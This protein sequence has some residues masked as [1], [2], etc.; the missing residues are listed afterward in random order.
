MRTVIL[1]VTNQQSLEVINEVLLNGDENEDCDIEGD[2]SAVTG[3]N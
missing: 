3:S 1:R 2:E